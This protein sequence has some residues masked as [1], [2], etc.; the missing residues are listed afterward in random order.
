VHSYNELKGWRKFLGIPYKHLG[1]D[2]KG[3]DCYGLLMLYAKEILGI[4][5][6][7]W[8]YEED[9]SK[10]GENYFTNNYQKYA[11]KVDIPKRHDIIL[12]CSDLEVRIPNHVAI[13]VEEPNV[14][15]QALR[16]GVVR[17]NLYSPI[18]M[19]RTEGYYRLRRN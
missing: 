16:G 19:N 8:W 18:I 12:I 14:I 13:L 10:N 4:E 2:W 9:W 1:R 5:L 7:D 15:I 6:I 3:L 11:D 17:G